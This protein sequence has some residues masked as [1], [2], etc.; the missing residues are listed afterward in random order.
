MTTNELEAYDAMIK[1]R[2]KWKSL[3]FTTL[4]LQCNATEI[5]ERR[6]QENE[7]LREDRDRYKAWVSEIFRRLGLPEGDM[8]ALEK[9]ILAN[10]RD[11]LSRKAG[12]RGADEKEG[13]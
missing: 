6:E 11:H 12:G 10:V 13:V 8:G 2:D 3:Y 5:A 1:D 9:F 4:D 7:K